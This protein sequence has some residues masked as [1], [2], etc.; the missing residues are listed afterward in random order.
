[1]SH[2][3]IL[4]I[5]LPL[6]AGA[7]LLILPSHERL[8]RT[9]SLLATLALLPLSLYLLQLADDGQLRVYALG[10]WQPRICPVRGSLFR[11]MPVSVL[12]GDGGA[13]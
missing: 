5:L 13:A 9:L 8:K 10:D 11:A 7:L 2:W 4:P 12:G 3:P 1:M 6:F